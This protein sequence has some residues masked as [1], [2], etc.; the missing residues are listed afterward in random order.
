[1]QFAESTAEVGISMR[2]PI[3]ASEIPVPGD[4]I[5]PTESQMGVQD[6]TRRVEHLPVQTCTGYLKSSLVRKGSGLEDRDKVAKKSCSGQAFA[7]GAQGIGGKD[8]ARV[9]GQSFTR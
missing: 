6:M 1:M 4:V 3:A 2:L 9:R 5:L 7:N 8:R